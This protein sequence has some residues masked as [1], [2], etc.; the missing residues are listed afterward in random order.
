MALTEPLSIYKTKSRGSFVKQQLIC[1]LG[2]CAV[3]FWL[4]GCCDGSVCYEVSLHGHCL[5]LLLLLFTDV[6]YLNRISWIVFLLF[7]LGACVPVKKG[8]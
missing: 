5:V 3:W 6:F 2:L 4:E 7:N 8:K 1:L